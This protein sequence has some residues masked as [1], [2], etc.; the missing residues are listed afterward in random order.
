MAKKLRYTL[1]TEHFESTL[2]AEIIALRTNTAIV[3]QVQTILDIL[4]RRVT[5][6]VK[7]DGTDEERI[8]QYVDTWRTVLREANASTLSVDNGISQAAISNMIAFIDTALTVEFG[9]EIKSVDIWSMLDSRQKYALLGE[10]DW[11]IKALDQAVMLRDAIYTLSAKGRPFGNGAVV[12]S[13]G[14]IATIQRGAE[15]LARN[16]L[17]LITKFEEKGRAVMAAAMGVESVPDEEPSTTSLKSHTP[18]AASVS[19]SLHRI[20]SYLSIPIARMLTIST[21]SSTPTGQYYQQ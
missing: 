4:K 8:P 9:P 12:V 14:D 19:Q 16:Y 15:L 21:A 11:P 5:A 7:S 1:L 10:I 18:S 17:H 6:G 2:T 13:S 3:S 20:F